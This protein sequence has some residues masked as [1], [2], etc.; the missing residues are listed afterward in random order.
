MIITKELFAN[1]IAKLQIE[2]EPCVIGLSGVADSLCLTL[3]ANEYFKAIGI[4]LHA[5]IVDHKLRPESSTE[6]L[7]IIGILK[8][9]AIDYRVFVWEHENNMKG[10]IEQKARKIRYDFL[11]QYCKE[12]N[13]GVLMTAHHALDQW[14]TFFMRLSRGSSLKGLCCIK[15]ISHFKDVLL[16]RPLL[17]FSP[18]TIKATLIHRFKIKNYV[19]DPS[20]NDDIYERV[21]WRKAYPELSKK[22]NLNMMNIEKTISRLKL[23]N[24]F[25]DEIAN[26]YYKK[27]FNGIYIDLQ[28]YN[29]LDLELKVRILEKVIDAKSPKGTHIVSYNLL[30]RV[31]NE[32][33]Q[34]DFKAVNLSRLVFRRYCKN[35]IKVSEEVR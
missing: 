22:Y 20:N 9:H 21:R 5:C 27:I 34:K 31:A 30:R 15:P 29:K 35:N 32:I 23:S 26:E 18:D 13:A 14:E 19:K 17:K 33:C 6:I 2:T 8:D 12:V 7:P 24:Q 28:Q 11:Y 4:S 1:E 10:S 16:V 3:L 25:I